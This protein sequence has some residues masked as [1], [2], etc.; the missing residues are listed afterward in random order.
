MK[1]LRYFVKWKGSAENKNTWEPPEGMRN[2]Q[3]EVERFHKEKLEMS[4]PEEV[5]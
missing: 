5:E 4:G 3:E 2:T 1:Q